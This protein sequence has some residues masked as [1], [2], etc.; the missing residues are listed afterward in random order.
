MT[1]NLKYENIHRFTYESLGIL[2]KFDSKIEDIDKHK[3]L[4]IYIIHNLKWKGHIANVVKRA[5][6]ELHL[7][8]R[9]F[10]K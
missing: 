5:N 3:N 9:S 6:T 2:Y 1:N 10:S 7:I 4:G 8:T